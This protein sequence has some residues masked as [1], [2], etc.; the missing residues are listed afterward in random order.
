MVAGLGGWPRATFLRV[1]IAANL[2]ASNSPVLISDFIFFFSG[3][4]TDSALMR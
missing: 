1:V 2:M 4:G 3:S